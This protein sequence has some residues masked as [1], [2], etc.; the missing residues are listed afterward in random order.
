MAD[1][2][3]GNLSA[4]RRI[5][6]F[7]VNYSGGEKLQKCIESLL[8]SD[9]P[10]LDVRI[11]D[12]P[13]KDPVVNKIRAY[14]PEVD[15]IEPERNVGY[16]GAIHIAVKKCHTEQLV[17]CNNDLEFTPD[18]ISKLVQT[19]ETSG[20]AAVSARIVNPGESEIESKYNASLNP[21]YFLID[22]VFSDRSK[23]VYPSG[24]CFLIEHVAL[25]SCLPPEKFFLYYEDVFLGMSLRIK[26]SEIVQAND[27]VVH[28][29]HG[30]SVRRMSSY[31]LT[32]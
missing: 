17:I 9:Y 16:A 4:N 20:A 27:A 8:T 21:M 23:A 25:T 18:C 1:T 30:Y 29:E 6:V 28:H 11:I 5:E 10:A 32:F 31:K 2:E 12:N 7:I 15:V 13:P 22:G 3:T 14:Y 26:G 24:A 19:M